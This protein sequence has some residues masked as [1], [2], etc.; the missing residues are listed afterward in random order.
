MVPSEGMVAKPEQRWG[1]RRGTGILCVIL[2]LTPFNIE[3]TQQS[4]PIVQL[5]GWYGT[6]NVEA[7]ML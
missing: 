3:K 7:L 5:Q 1:C 2:I 4:G 6:T